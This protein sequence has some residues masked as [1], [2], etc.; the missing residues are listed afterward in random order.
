MILHITRITS[1]RVVV[2]GLS[3]ASQDLQLKLAVKLE[4][5]VPYIAPSVFLINN[6]GIR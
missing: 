3:S 1:E 2:E 5:I 4:K 6:N